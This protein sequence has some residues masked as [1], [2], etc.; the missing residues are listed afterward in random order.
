MGRGNQS[1]Q[2][3]G[4]EVGGWDYRSRGIRQDWDWE[5]KLTA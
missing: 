4:G 5:E 1:E 2:F 3:G